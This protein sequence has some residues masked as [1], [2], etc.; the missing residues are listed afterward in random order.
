MK[1][2]GFRGAA[3]GL[4][5]QYDESWP[6]EFEQAAEEI[7]RQ[8]GE[9]VVATHHVGSTAVDTI[10]WSKPVI[11]VVVVVRDLAALDGSA[12]DRLASCGFEGRGE[13]G[14]PGRRYFVRAAGRNRL[15]VHVHCYEQG[16]AS[17]V[18]YL[19]FRD[20]LRFHASE[21][22]A[23]SDLKK[24]L[25]SAHGPDRAAYQAGKAPFI[26]RIERVAEAAAP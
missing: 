23:Y 5:A 18:R 6:L 17:I 16:D 25:A 4:L 8:I 14:I 13:Y 12:T 10:L 22:A 7:R 19:R 1:G 11:D 15:K 3:M 2:P 20:Y 26:A 24:Q 9:S 21:A